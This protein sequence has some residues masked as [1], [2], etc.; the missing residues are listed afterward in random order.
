MRRNK[1]GRTCPR[2]PTGNRSQPPMQPKTTIPLHF[3]L[4]MSNKLSP[5][6]AGGFACVARLALMLLIKC[7][8]A[9]GFSFFA[10]ILPCVCAALRFSHSGSFCVLSCRRSSPSYFP[11]CPLHCKKSAISS[12]LGCFGTAMNSSFSI[13]F[14]C[15]FFSWLVLQ[16]CAPRS[17]TLSSVAGG[18]FASAVFEIR[19][20]GVFWDGTSIH[21]P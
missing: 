13:C 4:S 3:G 6:P 7:C 18:L 16:S 8:I 19:A 10:S 1:V 17:C 20:A 21:F 14:L 2:P 5:S 15:R 11:C 12:N 9:V